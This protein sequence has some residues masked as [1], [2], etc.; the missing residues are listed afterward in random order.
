[1]Y[2][3]TSKGF[4]ALAQLPMPLGTL[5]C[6]EARVNQVLS[7]P[8]ATKR[9][10]VQGQLLPADVQIRHPRPGTAN[11]FRSPSLGG[12]G[13][14]GVGKSNVFA[15]DI[16]WRCGFRG[17]LLN[18]DGQAQP[19]FVYPLSNMLTTCDLLEDAILR[20]GGTLSEDQKEE[21]RKQCRATAR[22]PI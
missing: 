7:S 1:M 17:P 8:S 2:I 3:S 18:F 16:A 19:H 10:G 20:S 21:F 4:G 15:L 6:V 22:R 12:F 9:W 13:R 14:S 5:A 11:R